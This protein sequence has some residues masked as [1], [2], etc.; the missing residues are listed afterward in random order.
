MKSKKL[1]YTSLAAVMTSSLLL[2][3][4][5]LSTQQP[6]D[7]T[8][9]KV[10]KQINKGVEEVAYVEDFMEVDDFEIEKNKAIMEIDDDVYLEVE[11]TRDEK[12]KSVAVRLEDAD[13]DD[14]N[15]VFT[16]MVAVLAVA[17]D[18]DADKLEAIEILNHL[19]EIDFNEGVFS[20]DEDREVVRNE[21][22]YALSMDDEDVLTLVATR[23]I[24][25]DTEDV[26]TIKEIVLDQFG[27]DEDEYEEFEETWE[28]LDAFLHDGYDQEDESTDDASVVFE[29]VEEEEEEEKKSNSTSNK[30]TTSSAL[31]EGKVTTPN[32]PAKVGETASASI[33]NY[34]TDSFAQTTITLDKA[35]R[36]KDAIKMIDDYHDSGDNIMEFDYSQLVEGKT[37]LLILDYTVN[38]TSDEPEDSYFS[39]YS[40]Y[41]KALDGEST[42][43]G[44]GYRFIFGGDD[45]NTYE[46]YPDLEVGKPEN[47]RVILTVP[48]GSDDFLI[49]FE[50]Y[51]AEDYTYFKL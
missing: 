34:K 30:E 9:K 19:I 44:N 35:T 48:T 14:V 12:V 8:L 17:L 51:G 36:G 2:G 43:E 21:V 37:E 20:Y 46:D 29:D 10:T 3:G 13:E 15:N 39:D 4:C 16:D 6:F 24:E 26:E 1:T 47:F 28:E 38:V 50:S 5:S 23:T 41:I 22:K 32:N 7:L 11:L 18:E 45:M 49:R 42:A 33:K 40:V 27:I 31:V 25:E